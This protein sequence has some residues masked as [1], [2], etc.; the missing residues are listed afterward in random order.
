LTNQM[1]IKL[2][3]T[4]RADTWLNHRL[5]GLKQEVDTAQ[6]AVEN[7]KIKNKLVGV[8]QETVTQQQLTAIMPQL[9]QARAER[10]QAEAQLKS[11]KGLSREQLETSS[12]VLSSDTIVELKKQEAEVKRK[13]SDLST[14]Y[15]DKHPTLANIRNEL[16]GIQEKMREEVS[17]IISGLT[18]DYEIANHKV[19]SL[20]GDLA[21]LEKQTGEG[22]EATV[23]LKQ[24]QL[25][26]ESGRHLYEEFL[27]RSKQVTEQQDLQ[28]ADAR[29]VARAAV[30][31]KPYFPNLLIFL[32]LGTAG[33]IG[34][35]FTLAFLI[36]YLDR[37]FRSLAH[38]EKV[39]HVTGLGIIPVA[40]MPAGVSP[41]DY[42]L[43]KPLS[44]YAEAFRA[45]RAAVHFSNVDKPPKVLMVT[46]SLPGEGKTAFVT[47][48]ARVM[49]LS[50][51]RVLLID[52]DMRRSA[53]QN[54]LKLDGTKPDLAMVL[55]HDATVEQA[56][57]RDASGAHIVIS[58]HKTPNLQDLLGS[59]A[60]ELFLNATRTIYDIIIIDTPPVIAVADMALLTRFVDGVIYLVKWATTTREAVGEGLKQ[61][62]NCN[63]T[64][65]GVVLTQVDL[66]AQ[67]RYG[68]GDFGYTDGAYGDY[69]AN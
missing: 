52:G 16:N 42:V 59:H 25:E 18:N 23:T 14:R 30:P 48:L 12:V 38:V 61:L 51:N 8:G 69:Y 63:V 54:L 55:A 29:V 20:E 1:D 7:Y 65:A 24:L 32:V 27:S 37:G 44:N 6:K 17:R 15:G 31:L 49:A 62:K 9:L 26:A 50:G 5:E 60:M 66:K 39:F 34:L 45:I 19:Q 41:S 33:G 56:I 43:N 46:S 4:Q 21:K 10:S 47:S 36:E 2:D 3:A 28:M 67:K 68:I 13:E 22:N 53:I 40:E 35:G 64:L 58:N 57:Q 11:V